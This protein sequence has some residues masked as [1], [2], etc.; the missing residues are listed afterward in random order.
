[1]S[2][3]AAT[4]GLAGVAA[5]CAAAPAVGEACAGAGRWLGD[6]LRCVDC[7][8]IRGTRASKPK[9]M[10]AISQKGDFLGMAFN[11]KGEAIQFRCRAAEKVSSTSSLLEIF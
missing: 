5:G 1:M 11:S 6:A 2:S 4:G 10:S 3:P 8:R 9:R 7:A